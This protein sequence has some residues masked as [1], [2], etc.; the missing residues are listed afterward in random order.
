MVNFENIFQKIKKYTVNNQ[1]IIDFRLYKNYYVATNVHTMKVS[2]KDEFV[3]YLV[4]NCIGYFISCKRVNNYVTTTLSFYG[5]QRPSFNYKNIN[6]D[7]TEIIK[8]KI[9]EN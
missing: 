2:N 5:G 4:G 9:L 6:I 3:L 8:R 7:L 1:N